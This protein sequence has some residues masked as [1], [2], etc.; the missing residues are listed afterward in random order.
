[1][2]KELPTDHGLDPAFNNLDR[3]EVP[4][5]GPAHGC[6]TATAHTSV[7][8]EMIWCERCGRWVARERMGESCA[9]VEG[10][11]E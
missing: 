7:N 1:M 11:S 6:H 9:G 3:P 5:D 2:S 8:G 4:R 10:V